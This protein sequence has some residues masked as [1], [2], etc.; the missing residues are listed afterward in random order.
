MTHSLEYGDRE[1]KPL[2]SVI[3]DD[4]SVREAVAGLIRWLGVRVNTFSSAIE[5]L[6]SPELRDSSCII[7][8]VQ[9]PLMTGIW[10]SMR[11]RS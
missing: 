4:E 3:D 5:F 10:I 8:D 11:M 2:V 7:A 1:A 6:G 9:M